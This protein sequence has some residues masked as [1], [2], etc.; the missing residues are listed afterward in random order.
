[1]ANNIGVPPNVPN[2]SG[3]PGPNFPGSPL[4]L[5]NVERKV[6]ALA[7]AWLVYAGLSAIL[8]FIGLAIA[9]AWLG[10]MGESGHSFGHGFGG[11]WFMPLLITRF[12]RLALAIRVGL[13]LMAG[14]GLM[15]KASWGRWVAIV[16]AIL[17]LI[18]FPFG[19]A[20][21]IW[22]LVVLLNAP[23]AAGYEAMARS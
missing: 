10:H 1:L 21:G 9:H 8:G 3:F 17:A 22:S 12:A 7:V 19:T 11:G 15:Q 5:A 6:N 13:A 2:Y 4:A 14:I 23:N 20:I 16:A 18:H